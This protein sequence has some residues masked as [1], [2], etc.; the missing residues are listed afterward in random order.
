MRVQFLQDFRG[1][2]TNEQYFVMGE[3]AEFDDSIALRLIA[4]GRAVE[5]AEAPSEPRQPKSK[6]KGG[7]NGA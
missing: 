1:R 7:K 6:V 3:E 5:V 2:L 4:D